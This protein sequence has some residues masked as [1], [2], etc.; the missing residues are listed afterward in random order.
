MH[1]RDNGTTERFLHERQRLF[2]I[3]YSIV[4]DLG[5]A[6]D[7][8]QEAWLRLCR[9]SAEI[10]DT[11]GWLVVTTSRLALDVM[12]SARKRREDYVGP[13]LPD[14]LVESADTDP[15]DRA[16]LADSVS[17]AVLVVLETLSPAERTAFVLHDVFGLP[18]TEVAEAV[19]RS[20]AAV[21]QLA[22][23][24]RKQVRGRTP[25][26]DADPVRQR[27]VVRAFSAACEG[28]DPTALLNLLDPDIVLRSDGG[29]V[30]TAAR[31]PVRGAGK[32]ARFLAGISRKQPD[33]ELWPA[34]VNG[35]AGL[36]KFNGEYLTSVIAPTIGDDRITAIDIVLHPE[37]LARA[38]ACRNET[39]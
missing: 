37:K 21:R 26:F 10:D 7:V 27:E 2:S 23:R 4:G 38:C 19:G 3:A 30:V 33:T 16:A 1:D 32:V 17:M 25:R 5:E 6:E 18:F 35:A 31:H 9:A 12:R 36:L 15:A 14:P 22:A 39:E 28:A 11:S 29:G 8:V 13:W 20:T 34:R 24:A